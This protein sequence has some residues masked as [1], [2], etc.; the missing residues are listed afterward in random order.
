MPVD[1]IKVVLEALLLVLKVFA[2]LRNLI[3]PNKTE[4]T[5]RRGSRRAAR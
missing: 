1:T 2:L 5:T 4:R 3:R